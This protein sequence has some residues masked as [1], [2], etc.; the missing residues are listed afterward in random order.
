MQTTGNS[1]YDV[2]REYFRSHS[3]GLLDCRVPKANPSVRDRITLTNTKLRN[4]A[5][6]IGLRIDR[7][8]QEL[9]KDLEH[10]SYK[11]DSAQ[12]DKDR[13]RGRTHLSDALG[14]LLWQECRPGPAVGE[15]P[16]RIV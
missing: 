10:V 1:D 9:V 13:D 3:A 2:V 15:Q 11:A 7:R 4:A 14:Y 8:C 6:E 16:G 5:G 12:I